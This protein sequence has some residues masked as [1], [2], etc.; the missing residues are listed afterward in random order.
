MRVLICDDDDLIIRWLESQLAAR[1]FEV[2][3]AFGGDEALFSYRKRRPFDYVVTDFRMPGD[4]IKDGIEL[5]AA[6]RHI[7]PLQ[8]IILHT[9]EEGLQTS[10][11][12]LFK[13]YPV[14]K[15]LRLFRKS[16]QPLLF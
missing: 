11:P 9:T 3:T 8:P 15:L 14:E 10:C 2:Y 16:L 7:D 12:V 6:I 1:G 13:P 4:K 5:V